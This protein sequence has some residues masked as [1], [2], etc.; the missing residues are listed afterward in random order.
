MTLVI[1]G[2][3]SFIGTELRRLCRSRGIEPLGIDAAPSGDPGHVT[4]DVRSQAID[5]AIPRGADALV[6]L[7]AVSREADCLADPRLAFDVNVGGTLNV[8]R[9]ARARG[10]RQILFASSEWVY[11]EVAAGEVQ[12]EEAG[13][14]AGRIRSEYALTKMVGE[15]L[16]EMAFRRGL[17][18]VTVLRL[19]IVYGPRA[20]HWSAVESLFHAVRSQEVVEVAGSLRTARRFIHVR[21]VA[22][23]ILAAV[24]RDG[25]EVFN[26]S[27]SALVTLGE[28][29]EASANLLGRR[30]RVLERDP[31]AVSIRNPDPAKARRVLGWNAGTPL[32]DGLAS[33][34]AG[35]PM[36]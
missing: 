19:A 8:I 28:V 20:D 30:P 24:G 33:L 10:V 25:Y 23:G 21:D 1:T 9:A 2:S 13:L 17:C 14:D 3:E 35:A 27:G 4:L 26:L 6:H 34:L 7:A 29:I 16:L 31:A 36:G 32:R 11:G 18:P 12:T 15:R 22:T 5:E